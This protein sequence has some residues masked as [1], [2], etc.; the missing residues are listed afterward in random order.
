MHA[1]TFIHPRAVG[2]QEYIARRIANISILPD[3]KLLAVLLA[4][5]E[6]PDLA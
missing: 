3:V 2:V 5:K 6:R 4:T 1:S